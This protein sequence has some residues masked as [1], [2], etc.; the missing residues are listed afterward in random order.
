MAK[1]VTR[2]RFPRERVTVLYNGVDT[3]EFMPRPEEGNDYALFMGR[4]IPEKGLVTLAEA[5]RGSGIRVV[6]AGTGPLAESLRRDYS[7][8]EFVGHKSG[9]ALRKLVERASFIVVPSILQENCPMVVL[10]AMAAGKAVIASR[11]GGIP[12]LVDEGKTGLLFEVGNADELRTKMRILASDAALR[13]EMGRAARAK[14]K[15][16]FSINKH[17]EQLL[18][19]YESVITECCA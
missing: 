3:D 4:L 11:N 10:E 1:I 13:A 19:I 18:R 6:A 7:G 8:L 15:I 12:E 5:Q 9:D 14:V 2:W 17:N 16:D